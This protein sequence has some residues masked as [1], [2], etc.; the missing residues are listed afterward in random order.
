MDAWQLQ[1]VLA[2]GWRAHRAL[3]HHDW[4]YRQLRVTSLDDLRR[5]S[6]RG[7]GQLD[8]GD[9]WFKPDQRQHDS[10]CLLGRA[11]RVSGANAPTSVGTAFELQVLSALKIS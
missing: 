6:R 10:L 8:R 9:L 11:R 3:I 1:R 7:E 2:I 4:H 5:L